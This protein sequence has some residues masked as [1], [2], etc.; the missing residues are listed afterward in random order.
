MN[1]LAVSV[2]FE[3]NP[4]KSKKS[5]K[6]FD[7]LKFKKL[8]KNIMEKMSQKNLSS[9]SP[10]QLKVIYGVREESCSRNKFIR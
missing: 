3:P 6:S 4:E 10:K 7:V 8:W 5:N 1:I 9:I 2:N